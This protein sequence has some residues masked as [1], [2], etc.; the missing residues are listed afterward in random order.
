MHTEEQNA[1][2]EVEIKPVLYLPVSHFPL[3]ELLLRY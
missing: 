1:C 2:K 3:E